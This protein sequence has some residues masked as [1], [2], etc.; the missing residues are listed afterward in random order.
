MKTLQTLFMSF[1]RLEKT[2]ALCVVILVGAFVL[3]TLSPAW[4]NAPDTASPI[5]VGEMFPAL[6]LTRPTNAADITYLG[7][8]HEKGFSLRD[9]AADIVMVEILNTFCFSCQKQ[10][11]VFNELHTL[12]QN[13]TRLKNR[14]KLLG[15][16]V[17]NTKNAVDHFK[18]TYDVQF[19]IIPDENYALYE[20]IGGARTPLTL[21]VR[22]TADYPDGMVLKRHHRLTYRQDM[23]VDD[24]RA[25]LSTESE[26]LAEINR[27]S[28]KTTARDGRVRPLLNDDA[29]LDLLRR[30]MAEE[31]RPSA[32]IEKIALA[33]HDGLY[34]IKSGP[35]AKSAFLIAQIVAKPP[36]CGVCH[37]IHFIYFFN[38]AGQVV[39]FHPIHLT[40][41]GNVAWEPKEVEVFR[42]EVVGKYL[43]APWS[44]NPD[45]PIVTSASITSSVILHNIAKGESLFLALKH[46]GLLDT[47]ATP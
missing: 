23:I 29:T 27:D 24:L 31:G 17:G 30:L 38:A 47:T 18:T 42:K 6:Q 10:A 40:K 9:V 13:D 37:D 26:N 3:H 33:G 32:H 19:P 14:V 16:A 36:T 28:K 25:M 8:R 5:Q 11:P 15:I 12:I 4:A 22:K 21:F 7:L 39:G 46:Q 34:A 1:L 35:D 2:C 20:A 41:Y 45:V 43:A 44:D